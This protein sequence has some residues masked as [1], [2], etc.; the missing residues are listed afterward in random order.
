M[1]NFFKNILFGCVLIVLLFHIT[2]P[3]TMDAEMSNAEH[4][5][6]HQ[7]SRTIID[8]LKL[9]FHDNANI[10]FDNLPNNALIVHNFPITIIK[11]YCNGWVGKLVRNKE[12]YK[13]INTYSKNY[14]I[15]QN[16][17]RAPPGLI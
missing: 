10:N 2:I 11:K 14:F 3:H 6:L 17:L 7:N 4:F 9:G 8:F 13:N 12:Y 15:V 5:A 16:G 1:I